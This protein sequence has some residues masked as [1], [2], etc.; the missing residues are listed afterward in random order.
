MKI[1]SSNIVA[2][3]T[4]Q[5]TSH[6]IIQHGSATKPWLHRGDDEVGAG[7]RKGAKRWPL[8]ELQKQNRYLLPRDGNGERIV[9]SIF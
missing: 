4:R 7:W 6:L 1:L 8:G 3:K 2:S 5:S 9:S